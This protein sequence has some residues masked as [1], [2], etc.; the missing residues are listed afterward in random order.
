MRTTCKRCHR[1]NGELC[2]IRRE[3]ATKRRIIVSDSFMPSN[4]RRDSW[5]VDCATREL[6]RRNRI[7]RM[8][9]GAVGFILA[10]GGRL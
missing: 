8:D 6:E 3:R 2:T 1:A 10:N 9:A 7:D 4:A 5:C